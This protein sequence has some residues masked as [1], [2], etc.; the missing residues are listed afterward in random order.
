[1]TGAAHAF[2][3]LFRIAVPIGII[4]I[5]IGAGSASRGSGQNVLASGLYVA[6]A[7]VA[8]A[9]VIKWARQSRRFTKVTRAVLASTVCIF[10]LYAAYATV[11]NI[12]GS[13]PRAGGAS[14]IGN[15][16]T[17]IQQSGDQSPN[18]SGVGGDVSVTYG[19]KQPKTPK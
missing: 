7:L 11:A 3:R 13:A 14:T 15:S 9:C 16:G 12:G 1:M 6:A 8:M 4:S 10:V 19:E 18:V 5:L 17:V 2:W